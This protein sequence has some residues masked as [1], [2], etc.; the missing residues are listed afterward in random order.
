MRKTRMRLKRSER[1]WLKAYRDEL[2][3]KYASWVEEMIIYGSKARGDARPDSD[4]D[5]LLI[6]KNQAK[7]R[8][9]DLRGVG[10]LLAAGTDVMSSIMVYTRRE[11]DARKESGSP[12]RRNVERDGV[13][14]L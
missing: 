4:L 2:V 10:H 14:V 6:V 9:R 8:K 13:R 3:A 7:A 12:F 5:V 1:A 11:W